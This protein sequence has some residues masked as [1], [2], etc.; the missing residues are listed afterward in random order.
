MATSF[1]RWPTAA[2]HNTTD[3]APQLVKTA[4][5]METMQIKTKKKCKNRIMVQLRKKYDSKTSTKSATRTACVFLHYAAAPCR[6]G[7]PA[8]QRLDNKLFLVC[9]TSLF[10]V[11][12][13]M[14]DL[15]VRLT[16]HNVLFAPFTSI[17]QLHCVWLVGHSTCCL[18]TAKCLKKKNTIIRVGSTSVR[19]LEI[20]TFW[21]IYRKL[22]IFVGG[23]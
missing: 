23:K 14:K 1:V 11:H 15:I 20:E 12:L 3:E 2:K 16:A 5:S 8:L 4:V 18:L 19:I 21:L 17:S 6:V 10:A 22:Q 9:I 7:A 13:L